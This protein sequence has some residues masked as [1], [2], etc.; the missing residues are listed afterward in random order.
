[1]MQGGIKAGVGAAAK[2]GGREDET[3]LPRIF[4]SVKWHISVSI[5]LDSICLF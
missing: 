5:S 4:L 2:E 3:D 1:M